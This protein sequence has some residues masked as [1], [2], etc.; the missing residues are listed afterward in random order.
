MTSVLNSPAEKWG[1]L[2]WAQHL[3]TCPWMPDRSQRWSH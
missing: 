2:D 1:L 3:L